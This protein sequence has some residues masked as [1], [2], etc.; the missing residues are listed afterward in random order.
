M[1][2][3]NIK[4][5]F[6]LEVLLKNKNI[7][8]ESNRA[9]G[10]K[11]PNIKKKSKLIQIWLDKNRYRVDS[12]DIQKRLNKINHTTKI[13]MIIAFVLGIISAIGLLSYNGNE[14][15]NVLYFIFFTTILP[16]LS[17]IFSLYSLLYFTKDI[18]QF[19]IFQRWQYLSLIFYIAFLLAFLTL[20]TIEDIAFLWSTTLHISS[21]Q[22]YHIISII[23]LPWSW[24]I[25]SLVS[26]NLIE[27]SQYYR[28]GGLNKEIIENASILGEWWK[29]LAM[30]ILFYS[31][32]LRVIFIFITNRIL[33]K[34][35]SNIINIKTKNILNQIETPIITTISNNR[36]ENINI[37]KKEYQAQKAS[38][39]YR[40]I[41]GYSMSID[42][43]NNINHFLNIDSQ[44]IFEVG[45][46]QSLEDDLEII[47]KI[48]SK[49]LIYIHSWEPPTMDFL[50]FL[51][52]INQAVDIYPIGL[53]NQKASIKEINIWNRWV[54]EIDNNKLMVVSTLND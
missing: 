42:E 41:L 52:D 9:I 19:I 18:N 28:L 24:A 30:N 43:I 3:F 16:I 7:D 38:D 25:D 15:V 40:Y 48:D 10:L 49:V 13:A 21:A 14:P 39:K 29:F 36:E 5:Y 35:L 46:N 50:D 17:M 22:F 27:S 37:D 8:R 4:S 2:Q 1:K 6:E 31:I 12:F 47:S 54:E 33:N 23:S 44:N 26:I 53:H 51:E 32:T 45:G 20:I 11:Y 34:K